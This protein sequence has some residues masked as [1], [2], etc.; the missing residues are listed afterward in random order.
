MTS[1]GAVVCHYGLFVIKIFS[2]LMEYSQVGMMYFTCWC[3]NVTIQEH[4][5]GLGRVTLAA[6]K[7]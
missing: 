6:G 7:C 5:N 4:G 2:L 3:I 1:T